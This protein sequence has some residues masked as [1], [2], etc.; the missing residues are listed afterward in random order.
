M[1]ALI[2]TV[3]T[4][5]EFDWGAPFNRNNRSVN[6]LQFQEPFLTFCQSKGV[7]PVYLIDYPVLENSEAVQFL[8]QKADA[9][10]IDLGTHL[11]P[12]VN[13]PYYENN[14]EAYASYGCNLT[15][16]QEFKK[17]SLLTSKFS[18]AFGFQPK[19][20]KAGRY[21]LGK[22]T[23]K[24]LSDLGYEIDFSIFARA[25]FSHKFGPDFRKFN[26]EPFEIHKNLL[27]IPVTADY[28][29]ILSGFKPLRKLVKSHYSD[30]FK[31]RGLLSKL[32]LC[33]LIPLSPEF[34]SLKEMQ[35]VARNALMKKHEVLH[36]TFHSS[37]FMPGATEYVKNQADL[38]FFLLTIQ[39]FIN[40]LTSFSDINFLSASEIRKY[41]LFQKKS[42]TNPN[43][44]AIRQAKR[45]SGRGGMVDTQA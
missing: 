2:I 25:D 16:E 1:T 29:G 7:K 30:H 20:F 45:F 8:K 24:I 37:T 12:W 9:N 3:D 44:V 38:D 42:F 6:N 5:E 32:K 35:T 13:P 28:S 21:G 33:N 18:E 43:T 36:F 40:Y 34:S 22:N 31:I 26:Y 15:L 41:L 39:E 17:L 27:E 19:M 14:D 11:H 10:V 23:A 4:E